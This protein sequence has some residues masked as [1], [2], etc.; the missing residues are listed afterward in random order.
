LAQQLLSYGLLFGWQDDWSQLT[1]IVYMTIAQM[2][3][4]IAKDLTKLGG[5][6]VTKLVT[7]EEKHIQLFK[8]MSLLMGWKNS[9]KV[10][11]YFA[12]SALLQLSYYAGLCTMMVL[13]ALAIPWA[14]LGLDKSLGTAKK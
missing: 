1:V 13:V 12:G 3:V 6:T 11:S 14:I 5:K 8:L 2:F 4:G 10:V 7:L 9:L